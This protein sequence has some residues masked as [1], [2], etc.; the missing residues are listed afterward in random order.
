MRYVRT[1]CTKH[2]K[3]ETEGLEENEF[4]SEHSQYVNLY[5]FFSLCRPMIIVLWP[6]RV[7]LKLKLLIIIIIIHVIIAM[8]VD[9]EIKIVVFGLNYTISRNL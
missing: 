3:I 1:Q 8:V 4:Q 7:Q 5:V 2:T 9:V 6:L